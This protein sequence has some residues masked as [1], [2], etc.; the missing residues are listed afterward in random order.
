LKVTNLS[1]SSA[2]VEVI[3]TLL[4]LENWHW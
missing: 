1:G 2:S 4:Q 3:L